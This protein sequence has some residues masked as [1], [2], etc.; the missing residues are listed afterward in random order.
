MMGNLACR[1]EQTEN[2]AVQQTDLRTRRTPAHLT[3]AYHMNR[4]VAG[5]RTPCS[6][7]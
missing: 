7:E 5:D 2:E 6:R 4:L 3:F 1:S